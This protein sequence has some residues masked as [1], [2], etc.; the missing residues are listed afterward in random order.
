MDIQ[1]RLYWANIRQNMDKDPYFKDF[2]LLDYRFIVVNRKTLCPLVWTYPYTRRLTED[3]TFGKDGN[4]L[5]RSPL[6]IGEE[7]SY[8]LSSRPVL[9]IGIKR[10]D[11]ND[12]V[13]WLNKE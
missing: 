4:I 11:S 9:P 1:A 10:D 5:F 7:L 2:E 6:K 12:I 8:Y 3:L 13:E